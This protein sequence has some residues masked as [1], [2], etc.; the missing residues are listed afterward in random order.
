MPAPSMIR[1][2]PLPRRSSGAKRVTP[3]AERRKAAMGTVRRASAAALRLLGAATVSAAIGW[4]CVSLHRWLTTSD[5][6]AIREIRFDGLRRADQA[7]LLASSGLR[8]GGNLF[9]ADLAAAARAIAAHPWVSSVRLERKLPGLVVAQVREHEPAALVELGSLYATDASGRIF[10]RATRAD[11]L[12]LPILTGLD[13]G[14][15]SSERKLSQERLVLALRL[16]DEWR[17]QGLPASRLSEVRIDGDGGL[18]LFEG[19]RDADGEPSLLEVRVGTGEF[20]QRLQRLGQ[21]RAALARRGDRAVRIELD[22][23]K[24]GSG[25]WATAQVAQ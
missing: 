12:D 25:S 9:R 7:D 10:K 4:A 11:A 5:A 24:A 8:V 15:W 23:A 16:L 21:L 18:T 2:T 20:A 22:L 6:F 19:Q 13:R 3:A 1:R 17:R 14:G